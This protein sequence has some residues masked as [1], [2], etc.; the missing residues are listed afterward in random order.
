M[1]VS[2]SAAGPPGSEVARA[3]FHGVSSPT[4]DDY[5]PPG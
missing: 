5:K 4:V 3:H 2:V 1:L